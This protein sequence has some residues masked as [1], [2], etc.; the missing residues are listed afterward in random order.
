M[1]HEYLAAR[2]KWHANWRGMRMAS[3]ATARE[4]LKRLRLD[5]ADGMERIMARCDMEAAARRRTYEK[6]ALA[7]IQRELAWLK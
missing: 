2:I 1:A 6:Q 5:P 3:L 4:R 7:E